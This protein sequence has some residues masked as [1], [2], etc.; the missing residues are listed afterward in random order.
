MNDDSFLKSPKFWRRIIFCGLFFLFLGLFYRDVISAVLG[1]WDLAL[2]LFKY[3][4][5][6]INVSLLPAMLKIPLN[7]LVYLV[8][9]IVSVFIVAQFVLPVE[10]WTDRLNAFWR[11]LSHVL[12]WFQGPAMFV[13]SGKLISQVGEED[14]MNA[15][16]IVVDLRSAVVVEP[17][18]PHLGEA[19]DFVD[20][21]VTTTEGPS[22]ESKAL[23]RTLRFFRREQKEADPQTRVLGPGV[24]FTDWGE[25]IRVPVDLRKQVRFALGKLVVTEDG[26]EYREPGVKAFTR[27]GIEVGANCYVVFSLSDPADVIRVA[28]WGGTEARHLYEIE[29]V[30]EENTV[31]II[32]MHQLDR[33]DAEEIHQAV[34]SERI[35]ASSE[36]NPS[37]ASAGLFPL[38]KNRVFDAAYGQA[39]SSSNDKFQWHELPLSITADI[40]RNLLQ[41]YNFDYL[42][43][44]DD[45]T[46]LPW[47]DALKPEFA[48]RVKYQGVL[49]YQ[50]IRP[51]GLGR[52]QSN[53][54]NLALD[55]APLRL[56]K[57]QKVNLEELEL[58]NSYPLTCQKSL[59]DRGIKVIAAG[60]SELKMPV[61]IRDNLVERWKA[62]W[63]REIQVVLARQEREAMQIIS[64]ARNRAQRDN[65]YFLSSLFKEEKHS[66]EALALL[67]FQ[68]LELAATDIKSQKDLPPREILAMLQNL[69]N[70]L[71]RERLEM[72]DRKIGWQGRLTDAVAALGIECI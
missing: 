49:S 66:T 62:R 65:A 6:P 15:G 48:R 21:P 70:W 59:R 55:G 7:G 33:T 8:V 47:K 46:H 69:H 44:A 10:S 54:W 60:F 14:N 67:I 35:T 43:S 5:P 58:S 13:K 45:P 52:L 3:K 30:K 53:D 40:F 34:H 29:W 41:K 68:S 27:D 1:W 24:H 26:K 11:V 17:A 64:S 23:L 57:D 72:E 38:D 71:L 4:P 36:A 50:L 42:Y 51:A 39:S 37:A 56:Q 32:N 63:E 20:Q 18:Y 19:D 61:N 16:V 12:K 2:V 28:Y 22:N 9:F 31:K 25:R